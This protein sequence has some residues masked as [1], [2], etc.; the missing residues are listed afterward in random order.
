MF[1][2]SHKKYPKKK[3]RVVIVWPGE[4]IRRKSI[5]KTA[6]KKWEKTQKLKLKLKRG[7]FKTNLNYI[8]AFS[9]VTTKVLMINVVLVYFQPMAF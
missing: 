4:K 2:C 9:V 3:K 5:E 7:K 8:S 6:K 1:Q